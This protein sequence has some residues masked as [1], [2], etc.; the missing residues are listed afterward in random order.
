[1]SLDGTDAQLWFFVRWL[2]STRAFVAIASAIAATLFVMLKVAAIAGA[3]GKTASSR[4][5]IAFC[6]LIDRNQSVK[7]RITS[8]GRSLVY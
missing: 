4:P 7:N 6:P 8:N 5:V 3:I 2:K 1:M